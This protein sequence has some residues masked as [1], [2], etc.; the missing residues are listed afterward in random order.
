[1]ARR[2]ESQVPALTPWLAG[3]EDGPLVLPPGACGSRTV[4]AAKQP[5]VS[6]VEAVI[7]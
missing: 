5:K 3:L 6:V 1:V 4:F 7:R 2:L